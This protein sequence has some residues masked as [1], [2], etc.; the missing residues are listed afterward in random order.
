MVADECRCLLCGDA[1]E[2]VSSIVL[3]A[4]LELFYEQEIKN[5]RL[6]PGVKEA[7]QEL[8]DMGLKLALTTNSFHTPK[9][10][11]IIDVLGIRPFFEEICISASVGFR[12]PDT[13]FFRA[14]SFTHTTPPSRLCVVGDKYNRDILGA[15]RLGAL[16]VLCLLSERSK[17]C[18][19]CDSPESA[20]LLLCSVIVAS[21]AVISGY[22][23][24]LTV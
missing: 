9:Q 13:R 10:D 21:V 18:S 16:S 15:K 23:L 24:S 19:T 11:K 5:T 6:Y 8:R 12:K 1:G 14:V 7:L 17:V 20:L 22:M 2:E 4:A 3:L